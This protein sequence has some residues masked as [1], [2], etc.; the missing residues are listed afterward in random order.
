MILDLLV[1]SRSVNEWNII[2]VHV[3][4][5][6]NSKFDKHCNGERVDRWTQSLVR[7]THAS[8]LA[9]YNI[10]ILENVTSD[11]A[12]WSQR[13]C[14]RRKDQLLEC[15][16]IKF[17]YRVGTLDGSKDGYND[18]HNEHYHCCRIWAKGGCK[19][20]NHE[21]MIQ[22]QLQSMSTCILHPVQTPS[23]YRL[24]L[25]WR[26]SD[27]SVT[28]DNSNGNTQYRYYREFYKY[29]EFFNFGSWRG[30]RDA[31]GRSTSYFNTTY[32]AYYCHFRYPL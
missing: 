16:L 6:S 24:S 12:D 26:G 9:I 32:P 11:T 30:A 25:Q 23:R 17:T 2:V 10:R 14:V 31:C 3:H 4:Y 7:K 29:T 20:C 21:Y 27:Q 19:F 15:L 28:G 8:S 22:S 18:G 13:K 1:G 5:S